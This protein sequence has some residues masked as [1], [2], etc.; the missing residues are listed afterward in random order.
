VSEAAPVLADFTFRSRGAVDLLIRTYRALEAPRDIEAMMTVLETL[1]KTSDPAA[2][3]VLEEA[4]AH[5]DPVLRRAAANALA[6]LTGET[7][8]VPAG[9]EPPVRAVDW[10]ALAALGPAARLVLETGRGRMVVELDA[11]Q[12]PLTVQTIA[13]FARAGRYDGVPFHRVVAN[14]VIQSGDFERGDGYGG[15]GFEIVSELTRIP[16]SRGTIGMASA[17][18]DTEGSQF[19]LTHS[20]QPHLDGRYTAFGALVEGF[21]ALDAILES[22]LVVQA[23]IEPSETPRPSRRLEFGR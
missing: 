21:E 6:A 19:F 14:F 23:T 17:G 16:Y 12:A 9:P 22:D 2:R 20:I 10:E 8:P 5:P 11:E 18:K 13:E 7:I 3:P 15:P 1:G 4:L